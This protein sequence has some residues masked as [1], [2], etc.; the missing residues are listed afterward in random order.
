VG[1]AVSLTARTQPVVAA[2]DANSD[3]QAFIEA[4]SVVWDH[5]DR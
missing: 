4:V 2:A 1:Q 3:D 5:D